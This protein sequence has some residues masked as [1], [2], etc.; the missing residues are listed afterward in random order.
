MIRFIEHGDYAAL[1]RDAAKLARDYAAD[2]DTM[3]N[4]P[5]GA[6]EF[7][8]KIP[9]KSESVETLKRPMVTIRDGGDC[10][11]KTILLCAWAIRRCVPCRMVLAGLKKTPEKFHHIFPELKL[12]GQWQTFD[13]TYPYMTLGAKM[14]PYDNFVITQ[15]IGDATK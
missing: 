15:T 5:A 6:Y 4:T 1:G 11:D 7:A 14:K 8:R 9:Y 3:P 13:A 12:L 2:T 10:D